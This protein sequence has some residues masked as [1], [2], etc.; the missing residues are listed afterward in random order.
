[1]KKDRRNNQERKERFIMVTTSALVLTALVVTGAYVRNHNRDSQDQGYTLDFTALEDRADEKLKEIA[2][3]SNHDR[4]V[5]L[6]DGEKSGE[7]PL[8][9]GSDEI[10]IPGLTEGKN[11]KPSGVDQSSSKGM[12]DG[13]ESASIGKNKADAETAKGGKNA[14]DGKKEGTSS[15]YRAADGKKEQ[16]SGSNGTDGNGS[17]TPAGNLLAGETLP[18]DTPLI[19]QET[20]A[21]PVITSELHF[22]Q[23]MVKPVSGEALIDYNME[24][25]VYFATL[26]QYKCNPAVIYGAQQGETVA[27][28]ADGR[29]IN[30]HDD[31]V[32]GHVLVLDLGD[33][34]QAIYG[35]VENVEIPIGGTILAG[36]KLA[37][38]AAPTKYYSVE[39][40]NLYFQITKNGESIDPKQFMQ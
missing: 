34:Y 18:E 33:G 16:A 2:L 39:G 11:G 5:A 4:N 27:A 38:V 37:T 23:S 32:L 25:G 35:Q 21:S 13:A 8:E 36:S 14:S 31:A 40:S 9:A 3:N 29:V 15:G 20:A 24:H 10:K 30:L 6:Q 28:C 1:M 22:A 26:D 7:G 19:I 12:S 17:P